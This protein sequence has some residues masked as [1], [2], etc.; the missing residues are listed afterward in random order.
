MAKSPLVRMPKPMSKSFSTV[1]RAAVS[2]TGGRLGIRFRGQPVILLTTTGRK[3]GKERT[4]PLVGLPLESGGW[5]IAGSN[6]GHDAHPGWYLN[7]RANPEATVQEGR[8]HVKVLARDAS[9]AERAE[10]W[11]RFVDLLDTYAEYQA[12]TDRQIPVVMLDP[13]A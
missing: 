3:T 2:A 1:H 7:L 8:R 5:V 6:G 4:W 10:H 11:S 13:A 12:A 9:P